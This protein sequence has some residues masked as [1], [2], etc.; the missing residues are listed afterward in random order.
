MGSLL[1][2]IGWQ[3]NFCS[4][5]FN[6][7]QRKDTFLDLSSSSCDIRWLPPQCPALEREPTEWSLLPAPLQQQRLIILELIWTWPF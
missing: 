6:G 7:C 4:Y 1:S 5:V 2:P 3:S